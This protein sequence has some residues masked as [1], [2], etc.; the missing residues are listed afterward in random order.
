MTEEKLN[1]QLN[2]QQFDKMQNQQI[3]QIIENLKGRKNYEKKKAAKLGF[4][5]L[6]EYIENKIIKQNEAAEETKKKL[7]HEKSSEEIIKTK[8]KNCGCC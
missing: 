2:R 7:K 8:K 6:Y 5:S 3:I 4:T 1:S